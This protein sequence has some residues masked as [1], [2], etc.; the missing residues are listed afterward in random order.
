M[1]L[2]QKAVHLSVFHRSLALVCLGTIFSLVITC[3]NAQTSQ[4]GTVAGQV[5]DESK[6]AVPGATVKLT[7]TST[8]AHSETTSNSEGRYVFSSVSPGDL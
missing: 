3:A 8:N 4:V 6:A 2:V 5:T 1:G 7:D